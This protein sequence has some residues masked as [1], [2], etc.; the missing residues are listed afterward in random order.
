MRERI[1][2]GLLFKDRTVKL[3]EYRILE[4][5]CNS[6]FSELVL[7]IEMN[8]NSGKPS[9]EDY[10]TIY[11]FH[12][13]L[14]IWLYKGRFDYEKGI[15]FSDL[16]E[17]ISVIQYNLSEENS[18]DNEAR[19]PHLKISDYDID[20]ILNFG[21]DLL[22]DDLLKIPRYGVW[23]Y[24]VGDKR[25]IM[26]N[27]DVYWEL[28]EKMPEIGCTVNMIYNENANE[29]I[30]Y[31]SSVSTFSN[32]ININRNRIYSLAALVVPRIIKGLFTDGDSYLER[33]KNK[34]ECDLKIYNSKLYKSP[35]SIKAFMNLILIFTNS[36]YK[37]IVYLKNENWFLLYKINAKH[38]FPATLSK[39]DK[40]RAPKG[41]YW[42]DPFAVSKDDQYYIFAEEYLF[43]TEKAHLSV[44]QLDR[45]GRLLNSEVIIKKPYHLSYPFV[46]SSNG[47]YFM[48][49]ETKSERNIQLYVCSRFPDKW[50]FSMNLMENVAAVDSTLYFH[51]NKWWLFTSIDEMEHPDLTYNEL[52][53]FYSDDLFSGHWK[54]HPANP[55]VTEISTSRCAGKIFNHKGKIF[56]PSQDCSGG[57][58]RAFNLIQITKLSESEYEEKLIT[59]VEPDWDKQ[60]VGMH[61]FNLDNNIIVMDACSRRKRFNFHLHGQHT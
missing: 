52:C 14:D 27:P 34:Y 3:W 51:D 10:S 9:L 49:P 58:G 2:I 1:K 5:L 25:S 4:K 15:D 38:S 21:F 30:I 33:L 29:T 47:K 17:G 57:Y 18:R 61:T 8:G 40:L 42:A 26:G 41:R 31:R 11:R 35:S 37:K 28:V 44:L 54:S 45:D 60:L 13:K 36:L 6:E 43:K 19:A 24:N 50:E 20:I 7:L 56:R 53:L 46:F 16:V 59:K 23:S 32:S 12:E 55:I 22:N 39:F 48:I